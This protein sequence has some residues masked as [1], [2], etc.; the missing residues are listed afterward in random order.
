MMRWMKGA[1]VALGLVATGLATVAVAKEMASDPQ[2]RARQEVMVQIGASTG[3][4]FS[5]AK[6]ERAFDAGAANA[7]L[8]AL[9]GHAAEIAPAFEPEAS[10]PVSEASPKIWQD[11]EK[12]AAM[13]DDLAT[14]ASGIEVVSDAD[15]RPAVQTL[16][17]ACAAC[18]KAF[19][20]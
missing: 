7:A 12:F 18:H 4:L 9:A 16:G 2:V 3:V 14:T 19:R 17:G 13:A 20:E 11:F 10:D 1:A 15:L 5:M 8:D 6:G